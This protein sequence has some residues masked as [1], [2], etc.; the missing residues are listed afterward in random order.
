MK[1]KL[2]LLALTTGLSVLSCIPVFAGQWKQDNI[3][4]WYQEDNGSYPVSTWKWID[5]NGDGVAECYYF[6]ASGYMLSNTSTPDSYSVNN[7]GAWTVNGVVQTKQVGLTDTSQEKT[8]NSLNDNIGMGSKD[9]I[10]TGSEVFGRHRGI[11]GSTG[12][13]GTLNGGSTESQS[14]YE[15]PSK[16]VY[17]SDDWFSGMD[18]SGAGGTSGNDGS[19]TSIGF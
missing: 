13:Q 5:G 7:D 14:N 10:K 1:K 17:A 12:A 15:D 8:D 16:G 9:K 4:W 11:G 3:G 2:I 19:H 18:P 6:N